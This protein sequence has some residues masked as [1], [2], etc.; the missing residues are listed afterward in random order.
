HYGLIDVELRALIDQAFPLSWVS[1]Q[2]CLD[3]LERARRLGEGH[4]DPLMRTRIRASC[5]CWRIWANGLDPRA[6]EEARD[7]LE[8]IRQTG[9]RAVIAPHLSDFGM[10]PQASA[11][12]R[13][14]LRCAI[15]SR[16]ILAEQCAENPYMTL[17]YITSGFVA[18]LT[19]MFLGHFGEAL[20][21]THAAIAMMERNGDYYRAKTMQLFA[22]LTHLYAL[23]FREVL[24]ICESVWPTVAHPART[25]ERR[26]C[27]AFAGLAETALGSHASALERFSRAREEMD[28]YGV[29]FSWHVRM[30]VEQGVTDCLLATG[31]LGRARPQAE[32]FLE[33]TL[34]TADR[35]FQALAWEAN[36]RVAMP[37]SDLARAADCIGKAVAAIE[38]FEVPLAAWRVHAT[39][40]ACAERA[41]DERAAQRYRELSRATILQLANSLPSEEPL[42]STFLSAP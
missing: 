19:L 23:D 27:L 13:E 28:R 15:E 10:I 12:Y 30:M 4:P 25:I 1:S 42:R 41:D 17:A 9:D 40:A 21:E 8:K 33:L 26:F 24:A 18:S 2:R 5:A 14:A 31:D 3:A 35:M 29:I 16:E 36:A 22:A 32:R 11:R 6:A 7:A 38:G 20:R 39:A 34:A 37:E